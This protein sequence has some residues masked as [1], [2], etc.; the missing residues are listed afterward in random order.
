MSD[1]DLE[2]QANELLALRA[3]YGDD[4][5][6]LPTDVGCTSRVASYSIE[7]DLELEERSMSLHPPRAHQRHLQKR[8]IPTF[9]MTIL[10]FHW[11]LAV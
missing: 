1:E 8:Y 5:I 2:E 4:A 10:A 9:P 6:I 3:I 7:I 11:T